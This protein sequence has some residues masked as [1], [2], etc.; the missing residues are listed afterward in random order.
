MSKL[1]II[2][3]NIRS[4]HNIGA[5]FR[6]CDGLGVEKLYLVGISPYPKI[7][8]DRRLPH[9]IK[10]TANK[11]H[12]TALGAEL[13][14]SWDYFSDLKDVLEILKKRNYSIFALEQNKNAV[15]LSNIKAAEKNVLILGNEINGLS[16]SELLLADKII[17]ITMNGHKESHNVITAA[18][19]ASYHLLNFTKDKQ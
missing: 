2:A 7:Q 1:I 5:L 4:A 11:I 14:V 16:E 3:N 19:I 8:N 18:A 10:S 9:I 17:E 6:L 15:E 12:K 13:T